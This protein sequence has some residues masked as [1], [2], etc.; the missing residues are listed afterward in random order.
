VLLSTE[1]LRPARLHSIRLETKQVAGHEPRKPDV[2]ANEV[3]TNQSAYTRSRRQ[4][5]ADGMKLG[6]KLAGKMDS[7]RAYCT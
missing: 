3:P 5:Q 1:R 6:V 7:E 2:T 4:F